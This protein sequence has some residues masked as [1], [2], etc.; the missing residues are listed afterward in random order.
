MSSDGW[1]SRTPQAGRILQT[2]TQRRPAGTHRL[3]PVAPLV[4]RT[5][6]SM[7]TFDSMLI[8]GSENA[9]IAPSEPR[10]TAG[11]EK[12]LFG[13]WRGFVL[14]LAFQ[15]IFFTCARRDYGRKDREAV[16]LQSS[17]KADEMVEIQL[18]SILFHPLSLACRDKPIDPD[19]A[20]NNVQTLPPPAESTRVQTSTGQI[21]TRVGGPGSNWVKVPDPKSGQNYYVNLATKVSVFKTERESVSH[22]WFQETSWTPP[23]ESTSPPRRRDGIFGFAFFSFPPEFSSTLASKAMQHPG[24]IQLS[25]LCR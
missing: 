19:A 22:F 1:N 11:S 23:P 21:L 13:D 12:V 8:F 25:F 14:E 5:P 16:L 24:G 7:T 9:S 17:D 6:P 10:T 2:S 20:P 3:K 4:E 15:S 18:S